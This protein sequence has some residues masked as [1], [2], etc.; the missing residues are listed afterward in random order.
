M[1]DLTFK[2]E[3]GLSPELDLSMVEKGE[4]FT[5][6]KIGV[7][8]DLVTKEIE[9]MLARSGEVEN[10]DGKPEGKDAMD[11]TLAELDEDGKVKEGGYSHTTAFAFD[12]LKLKKDQTAIGKLMVGGAYD[13]FNVFKAFDKSKEEIA[14]AILELDENTVDEV[15]TAFQLTLNKI[16]RVGKAEMNQ[17]Y[18]DKLYGE[19]KV[20]SEEEYR[21]KVKEELSDYLAQA[22]DNRLK[23]DIFK[24]F[25]EEIKA[26]LPDEFLKRWLHAT[27]DE[28]VSEEDIA[29]EYE[30]FASDLKTSLVFN[31]I[32]KKGEL[33]VEAD[34]LQDEVRRNIIQQFQYYGMPLTDNEEM[35]DSMV[36]RM[37]GDEKQLRQ[38][39]DQLMDSKIFEY[40]KSKVKIADKEVTLDDFNALNQ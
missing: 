8:E 17:A 34:E 1:T 19:G 4:K 6:Y 23:S 40:L 37:M 7:D 16:N 15:G 21:A 25:A 5:K 33:K 12:Q 20:N 32:A 9:N 11:V 2:Y 3:V 26:D 14:K 29:K 13:K 27:R 22:A 28:N 30:A 18:F 24:K 39:H 38:T 36:Q 31:S 35:L 10:P